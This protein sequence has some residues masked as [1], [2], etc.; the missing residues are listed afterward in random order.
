[1]HPMIDLQ[2]TQVI[3]SIK[4][5]FKN[6]IIKCAIKQKTSAMYCGGFITARIATAVIFLVP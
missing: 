4:N 2:K 5:E 1:M 3:H 6:N